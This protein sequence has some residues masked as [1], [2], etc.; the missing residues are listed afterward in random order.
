MAKGRKKI[1]DQLKIAKGTNQPSRMDS[2]LEVH[3]KIDHLPRAPSWVAKDGKKIYK[4]ITEYLGSIGILTVN[5]LPMIVAYSNELGKYMEYEKQSKG[6]RILIKIDQQKNKIPYQNP[7]IKMA[8]DALV[9]A[10]KIG[11]EFGITPQAQ[12]RIMALLKTVKDV[13]DEFFD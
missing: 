5:N 8:N 4:A 10:M 7:L 9:N 1:P 13:N 2:S 3:E 6:Q 12:S 11:Q